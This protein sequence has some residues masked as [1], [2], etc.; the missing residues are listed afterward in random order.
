M[1][2]LEKILYDIE[3][4]N[5][6]IF[7]NVF[8]AE[9]IVKH[10]YINLLKILVQKKNLDINK[11]FKDGNT[12][13]DIACHKDYLQ[14]V[15]IIVAYPNI[16]NDVISNAFEIACLRGA[17]GCVRFLF[18]D[19][20]KSITIK[21]ILLHQ[22]C[23]IGHI[24]ILKF[25]VITNCFNDMNLQDED[26][27]T[28]LMTCARWQQTNVVYFLL[29]KEPN[30]DVNMVNKQG[31]NALMLAIDNYYRYSS[32]DICKLLLKRS[33]ININMADKSGRT[34]AHY[35]AASA[36]IKIF[37]LFK[38]KNINWNAQNDQGSTCLGT[39]CT[40]GR[41]ELVEALIQLDKVDVNLGT[42]LF[43]V[44]VYGHVE[45]LD[46]LLERKDFKINVQ[47][48]DPFYKGKS[49][50]HFCVELEDFAKS[51]QL[52]KALL[53]RPDI[54]VNIQDNDG[55]TPLHHVVHVQVLEL[56]LLERDD[57]D[58]NRKN[59]KGQ[60]PIM[61][62]CQN[63]VVKDHKSFI[64]RFLVRK[65]FQINLFDNDSNTLLNFIVDPFQKNWL[66][67][68]GAYMIYRA[69]WKIKRLIVL[70]FKESSFS[71]LPIQL[72]R[73]I[74]RFLDIYYVDDE[75]L[76]SQN[77]GQMIKNKPIYYNWQKLFDEYYKQ[78]YCIEI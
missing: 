18:W 2:P 10:N 77:G 69:E 39:A 48:T 56:L 54:D 12:I 44:I 17:E 74:C 59:Y 16:E 70:S 13:L 42:C 19:Y 73:Y 25:L 7:E 24:E 1:T 6:L 68:H 11:K 72:K 41:L 5:I 45:V 27:F 43:D 15:K 78:Y 76:I 47:Q 30:I 66:I 61:S 46:K 36:D 23:M 38:D 14:C 37:D 34:I 35:I 49:A 53:N 9:Y 4:P 21:P 62:I 20:F 51:Y 22:L 31:M 40:L 63:K 28:P 3:D 65:D 67:Q 33:D 52:T 8:L 57:V 75:D 58:I 60:T 26:G 29:N 50:L 55:N 32:Y 64:E 71:V